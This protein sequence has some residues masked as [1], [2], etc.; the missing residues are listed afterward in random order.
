M[1]EKA[2]NAEHE[3]RETEGRLRAS[4]KAQKGNIDRAKAD[5]ERDHTH[6]R[7]RSRMPEFLTDS[8]GGE[9]K[10]RLNGYDK[11]ENGELPED[12]VNGKIVHGVI[13]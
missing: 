5:D 1:R 2:E 12:T 6:G 4:R 11:T 9:K 8:D 10:H 3:E 13:V 7:K